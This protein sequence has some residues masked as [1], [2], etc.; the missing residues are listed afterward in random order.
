[1]VGR[2]VVAVLV[3]AGMFMGVSPASALP[4]DALVTRS[5]NGASLTPVLS[6]DGRYIAF[7]SEASNL[8]RYDR[9]SVSDV[10]VKDRYTDRV[11]RVSVTSDGREG[12]AA[13]NL[14][15]HDRNESA[16]I[17]VVPCLL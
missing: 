16:D 17:F 13:S 5:A 11:S 12:E 8:V 15:P 2:T 9:N 14:V 1:M 3:A 7:P 4:F 6:A 10:F